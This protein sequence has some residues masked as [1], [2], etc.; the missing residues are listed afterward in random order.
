M[1]MTGARPLIGVTTYRQVSSWWAWERDAALVPARYVD[2]IAEAGGWPLLIPPC[3][4]AD[5]GPGAGAAETVAALDG[6]VL[7]GGGDVGSTEYGEDPD[8]RMAGVSPVRDS[9]ELALLAEAL[10]TELPVLA[11]CRGAQLLNVHLGGDLVQYLPDVVGT[12]T[13]QPAP[14]SFGPVTVMAEPGT[15]IRCIAGD[16]FDVLCSHHQ[17]IGMLG[18]D[19]VVTARAEDGVVEAIELPSPAF[20]MGVQWHPEECGGAGLFEALVDAARS[21]GRA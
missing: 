18:R 14:G 17:A 4:P 3:A 8:P 19:L 15:R 1:S 2:H 9:S 7:I 16:R 20:V 12:S 10:R 13:H 6:L 5:G 11:I 21:G